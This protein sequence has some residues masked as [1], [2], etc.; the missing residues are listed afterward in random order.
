M[1]S[2]NNPCTATDVHVT[3]VYCL[4][5]FYLVF[6][7]HRSLTT[8]MDPSRWSS[9]T[10]V[11]PRTARISC[12]QY[13]VPQPM[14]RRK[15]SLKSG[16]PMTFSCF[17]LL[18]KDLQWIFANLLGAVFHIILFNQDIYDDQELH[19]YNYDFDVSL[20]MFYFKQVRLQGRHLGSRSHSLHPFVWIPALCK[21][22][23]KIKICSS[24]E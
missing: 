18:R 7:H 24:L 1:A 6:C 12:L 11:W 9:G 4:S 5:L 13:V 19:V 14:W 17:K 22:P 21:V 2:D 16:K 8:L 10:L 3:E 23:V 20:I 15:F